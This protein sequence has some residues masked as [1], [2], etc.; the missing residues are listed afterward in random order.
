MPALSLDLGVDD[1]FDPRQNIMAGARYLSALLATHGGNLGLALASY[2]AGPP[3]VSLLRP[4][5][6][7][8]P[9]LPGAPRQPNC[10]HRITGPV[11]CA[12]VS[13][14]CI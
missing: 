14:E 10:Y 8:F 3:P 2:H 12:G 9:R 7:P 1:P 13:G 5:P 4:Y 6:G 11:S